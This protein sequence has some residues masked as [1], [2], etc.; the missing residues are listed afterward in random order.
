MRKAH[1]KGY[2][3][4]KQAWPLALTEL[5][6]EEEGN[7]TWSALSLCWTLPEKRCQCGPE[8]QAGARAAYSVHSC[9]QGARGQGLGWRNVVRAQKLVLDRERRGSG[10]WEAGLGFNQ[11]RCLSGHCAQVAAQRGGQKSTT[12]GQQSDNSSG[13][14]G[15]TVE[16][17]GFGWSQYSAG[18]DTELLGVWRREYQ[19]PGILQCSGFG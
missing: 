14:A 11:K 17:S 8:G 13:W 18:N 6:K 7:V 19:D 15:V 12:L 9:G 2:G 4:Q 16:M 1:I 5:V 3:P 10:V